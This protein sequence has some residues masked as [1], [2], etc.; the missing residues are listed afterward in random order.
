MARIVQAVRNALEHTAPEIAADIVD[1]GITLTGGGSL[2]R[3]IDEVLADETGLPVRVADDPLHCVALGA[4]L[5]SRTGFIGARCSQLIELLSSEPGFTKKSAQAR[6]LSRLANRRWTVFRFKGE[7]GQSLRAGRAGPH[8]NAF[9]PLKADARRSV[10]KSG[11]RDH[12][13]SCIRHRA[14]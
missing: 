3:E 12:S 8:W 10:S 2:L 7:L 13:S 9:R 1:D 5:T 14:P 6:W 11:G 4:G